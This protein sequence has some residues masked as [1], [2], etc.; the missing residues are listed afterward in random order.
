MMRNYLLVIYDKMSYK[1]EHRFFEDIESM[2]DYIERNITGYDYAEV[3][4]K[5]K[6]EE[7]NN[8]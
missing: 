4:H 5:Y 1:Y 6:I 8:G 3:V 2:E 7:I